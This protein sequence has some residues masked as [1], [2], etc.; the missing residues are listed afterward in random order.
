MVATVVHFQLAVGIE[1]HLGAIFKA[2]LPLLAYGAYPGAV[3]G[4]VLVL[5]KLSATTAARALKAMAQL[6]N[7]N[8]DGL[9]WVGLLAF[10]GLSAEG[11]SCAFD[12]CRGYVRCSGYDR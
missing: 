10:F 4:G 6:P 3:C 5:T 11:R 1:Q 8:L 2:Y 7:S 12:G 9:V